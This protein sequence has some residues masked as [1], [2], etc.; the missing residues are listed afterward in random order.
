MNALCRRHRHLKVSEVTDADLSNLLPGKLTAVTVNLQA[1]PGASPLQA[2][3]LNT[4]WPLLRVSCTAAA[5]E[6]VTALSPEVGADHVSDTCALDT[7]IPNAVRSVTTALPRKYSAT[8]RLAADA[9]AARSAV[10]FA[11]SAAG[12]SRE[13]WTA[14][15][16]IT[17]PPV[18]CRQLP[19]LQGRVWLLPSSSGQAVPPVAAN[20]CTV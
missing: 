20:C 17:G 18:L 2:Q 13:T 8:E 6:A 9:D 7:G 19:P 5:S 11:G 1:V 3:D 12:A 10:L 14:V 4:A 16:M 15:T